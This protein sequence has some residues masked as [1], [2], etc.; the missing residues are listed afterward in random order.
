MPGSAAV[1]WL[2]RGEVDFGKLDDDLWD[3]V[4]GVRMG[5]KVG[6]GIEWIRTCRPFS[7]NFSRRFTFMWTGLEEYSPA[8]GLMRIRLAR[9]YYLGVSIC[10]MIG[11]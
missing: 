11:A 8:S 6:V 7:V 5:W 2:F 9:Y 3:L 1:R 4:G 10:I